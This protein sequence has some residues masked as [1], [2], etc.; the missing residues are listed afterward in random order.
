MKRKLTT[1]I[2][3]VL[4]PGLVLAIANTSPEGDS[5]YGRRRNNA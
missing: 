2:L 4:L 1:A 3:S 5:D